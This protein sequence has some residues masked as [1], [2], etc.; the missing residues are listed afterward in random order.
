MRLQNKVNGLFA[1][2]F[3]AFFAQCA[4][5]H[6]Q[7]HASGIVKFRPMNISIACTHETPSTYRVNYMRAEG[8]TPYV[9]ATECVDL[10]ASITYIYPRSAEVISIPQVRRWAICFDLSDKDAA[11]VKSLMANN[12]GKAM[13][14]GVD[15]KILATF[16]FVAPMEGNKFY[17][18]A[19][20]EESGRALM[21]RFEE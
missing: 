19:D 14:V 10:T 6:D 3:L 16:L 5:A 4:S 11:R 2:A 8:A 13:L 7:E 12:A 17:I 18:D 9:E 20:T 15:K 21:T 1:F